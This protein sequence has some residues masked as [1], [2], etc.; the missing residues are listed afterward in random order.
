MQ[1]AS[2]L[3]SNQHAWSPGSPTPG[4][5]LQATPPTQEAPADGLH[6]SSGAFFGSQQGRSRGVIS[7]PHAKPVE[8]VAP[9]LA[10]IKAVQVVPGAAPASK[11]MKE[12]AA[13]ENGVAQDSA[14]TIAARVVSNQALTEA[15]SA[16]SNQPAAQKRPMISSEIGESLC[17]A[18]LKE[19]C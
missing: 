2:E 16:L 8:D 9:P 12:R 5:P 14:W 13:V 18:F 4:S 17:L 19:M 3:W 11:G 15:P 6:Q 1:E 10:A 7:E